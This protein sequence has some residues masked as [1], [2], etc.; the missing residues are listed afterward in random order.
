MKKILY[1]L[2]LLVLTCFEINKSRRIKDWNRTF[3]VV[4]ISPF[5]N[6]PQKLMD[7]IANMFDYIYDQTGLSESQV[8]LISR[9]V[10]VLEQNGYF[11]YQNVTHYG[12][13]I[14]SNL[15]RD[16]LRLRWHK[17][18]IIT[19]L[20]LLKNLSPGEKHETEIV[21]KYSELLPQYKMEIFELPLSLAKLFSAIKSEETINI[22]LWKIIKFFYDVNTDETSDMRRKLLRNI[23]S[24]SL[25]IKWK[26]SSFRLV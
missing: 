22:V 1:Q 18:V 5:W 24:Y 20:D 4:W 25:N 8:E 16:V 9:F 6:C 3:S 12:N 21:E 15:I 7:F 14:R 13:E 23:L 17:D 10:M 19:I 11:I 26:Y 2:I